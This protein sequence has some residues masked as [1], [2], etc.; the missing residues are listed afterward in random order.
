MWRCWGW[1]RLV[2]LR[3]LWASTA[4][5]TCFAVRLRGAP[6]TEPCECHAQRHWDCGTKQPR[7]SFGASGACWPQLGGASGML[8]HTGV[9]V[10]P[11]SG[12]GDGFDAATRHVAGSKGRPKWTFDRRLERVLLEGKERITKTW[13]NDFLWNYF[14]DRGVVEFN[15]KVYMKELLISPN[16]F[17]QDEVLLRT[18]KALRP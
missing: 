9:V 3:G 17:V 16:E 13:L 15:E 8:H 11:R 5:P 1:L 4:S 7:L 18:I 2:L 14:D 10:A 6:T 12:S